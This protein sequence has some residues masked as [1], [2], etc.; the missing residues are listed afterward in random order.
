MKRTNKGLSNGQKAS[1]HIVAVQ[2]GLIKW[3]D[4]SLY[5]DFLKSTCGKD[6]STKMTQT[7][8][9]KVKKE[10]IKCGGAFIHKSAQKSGM[11]TSKPKS[12]KRLLEKIEAILADMNLSWSYADGIAD[13]MFGDPQNK[14]VPERFV[15]FLSYEDT[16]KVM[17]ALIKH[18]RRKHVKTNGN[19]VT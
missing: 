10:M 12:R 18:Q 15:R 2:I 17:I 3:G 5:R 7:D 16:Q 11:H 6:S 9:T 14:N 4:D 13:S 8:F 19:K 1:L